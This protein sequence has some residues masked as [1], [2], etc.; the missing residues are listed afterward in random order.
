[1]ACVMPVIFMFDIISFSSNVFPLSF[2]LESMMSSN[3]A[4]STSPLAC[5]SESPQANS[6]SHFLLIGLNKT[7]PQA[8]NNQGWTGE[9]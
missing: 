8:L 2:C 1:M 3:G 5:V 4:E 6:Q 7:Q 9:Y